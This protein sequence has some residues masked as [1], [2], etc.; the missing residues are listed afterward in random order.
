MYVRYFL[1]FLIELH[2]LV[3]SSP[4]ADLYA[5]RGVVGFILRVVFTL[6][7]LIS[8]AEVRFSPVL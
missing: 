5:Q 7:I 2:L 4:H 8:V 1:F 6:Y 3:Y